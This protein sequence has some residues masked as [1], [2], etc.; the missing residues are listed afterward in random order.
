MFQAYIAWLVI[1]STTPSMEVDH[2]SQYVPPGS[3]KFN[4]HAVFKGFEPL[5]F[6]CQNPLPF[7]K[8]LSFVPKQVS[9]LRVLIVIVSCFVLR[10]F[11]YQRRRRRRR[12]KHKQL[13]HQRVNM[14][15]N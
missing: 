8:R 6:S 3:L 14:V 10:A 12:M 15:L 5:R 9:L 2:S 11:I 13:Q 7:E 4:C 1:R